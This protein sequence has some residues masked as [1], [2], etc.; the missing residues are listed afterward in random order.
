MMVRPTENEKNLQRLDEMD[1]TM[2]RPEFVNQ[3]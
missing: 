1:N 3:V 2:L